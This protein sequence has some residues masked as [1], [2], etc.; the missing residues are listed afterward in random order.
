LHQNRKLT[1]FE[2]S[3]KP[4]HQTDFDIVQLVP[5]V[6]PPLHLA[7]ID[8]AASAKSYMLQ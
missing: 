3:N 4:A 8:F 1:S 2:A 7:F 5:A 6:P